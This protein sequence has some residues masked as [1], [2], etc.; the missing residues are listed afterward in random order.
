M[1]EE[2]PLDEFVEGI[3]G[4]VEDA[5]ITSFIIRGTKIITIIIVVESI[6]GVT[7]T[8]R[9]V[10]FWKFHGHYIFQPSE[11]IPI[12]EVIE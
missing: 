6:L 3:V 2:I 12:E 7:M 4:I 5:V 8:K 1:N 9:N 11:H 10:Y